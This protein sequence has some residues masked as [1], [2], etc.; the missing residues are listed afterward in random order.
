MSMNEFGTFFGFFAENFDLFALDDI[1][2]HHTEFIFA[3][4]DP[5]ESQ[6]SI[7]A[8]TGSGR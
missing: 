8:K 7:G 2:I 5:A 4:I 3:R 6:L 1:F